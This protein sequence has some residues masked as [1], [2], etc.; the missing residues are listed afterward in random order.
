MGGGAIL[1]RSICLSCTRKT[2]KR[3]LVARACGTVSASILSV[4]SGARVLR[5]LTEQ[6]TKFQPPPEI[7]N[8]KIA[9]K[10]WN[11]IFFYTFQTE[12]SGSVPSP[13]VPG[14]SVR[15]HCRHYV[16]A[17]GPAAILDQ[18]V[19]FPPAFRFHPSALPSCGQRRQPKEGR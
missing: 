18:A 13:C 16:A 5:Q 8:L 4:C 10:F 3:S 2:Q 9:Q 19:V 1:S 17:P 12:K 15:R 6:S 7:W 11:P 14:P